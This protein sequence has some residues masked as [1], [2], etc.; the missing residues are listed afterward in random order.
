MFESLAWLQAMALAPMLVA[1]LIACFVSFASPSRGLKLIVLTLPLYFTSNTLTAGLARFF[2]GSSQ[3][4]IFAD[5]LTVCTF[6][7]IVASRTRR[8]AWSTPNWISWAFLLF[9]AVSVASLAN[10]DE[11]LRGL[12]AL[13]SYAQ[14]VLLVFV[15]ETLVTNE[16]MLVSV[17]RYWLYSYAVVLSAGIIG[18]LTL[19]LGIDNYTNAG[20][21]QVRATFRF[22]NQLS[23][24]LV[25][26]SALLWPLASAR[27]LGNKKRRLIQGSLPLM[28]AVLYYSGSRSGV[29]AFAAASV[30]SLLFN[31]RGRQA[32]ILIGVAS[33]CVLG[34]ALH[35]V[36]NTGDLSA[37]GARYGEMYTAV[38]QSGSNDFFAF[39]SAMNATAIQAVADHPVLGGGIGGVLNSE[40]EIGSH[41]EIH[42]T[43]LGIAGQ[44]GLLGFAAAALIV[45]LAVLNCLKARKG[46]RSP[47]VRA[48]AE[49]CIAALAG[50][51]VHAYGNFDWR[52]RHL[53]LLL[54]LSS[55]LRIAAERTR[56]AAMPVKI[57]VPEP[58]RPNRTSGD[59]LGTGPLESDPQIYRA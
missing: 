36:G 22:P 49:G 58:W 17:M 50:V 29:S 59:R 56:W 12:M 8:Q 10:A 57:V 20:G 39:H 27:A 30:A 48:V 18:I 35:S 19:Y 7:G 53:W 21:Q 52:I 4:P 14:L 1:G 13:I 26:T 11:P 51:A 6:F 31:R 54:A 2:G 43:Y 37:A 9:L 3:V 44:T 42:N 5:L 24:Y 25:I 34:L 23:I 16:K 47:F 15:V 41:Y 28:L 40:V 46:S 32:Y 38:G 55:G 33:L 45:T